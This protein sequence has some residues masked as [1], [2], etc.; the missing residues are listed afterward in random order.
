MRSSILTA[1]KPRPLLDVDQ[2]HQERDKR[3]ADD[4]VAETASPLRLQGEIL[5]LL[6]GL[7]CRRA[8]F[9]SRLKTIH[10]R[11]RGFGSAPTARQGQAGFR[12]AARAPRNRLKLFS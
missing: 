6:T 11:R 5:S 4:N 2:R 3:R 7:G 8:A 12:L 10:R 9:R 1:K